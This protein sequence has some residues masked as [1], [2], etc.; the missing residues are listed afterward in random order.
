M[1]M[2]AFFM[3]KISHPVITSVSINLS[4]YGLFKNMNSIAF[5]IDVPSVKS[6]SIDN[7]MN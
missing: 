6:I 5:S 3:L 1:A 2:N 4:P 7:G